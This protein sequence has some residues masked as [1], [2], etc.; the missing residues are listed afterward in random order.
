[1]TTD[2]TLP[3]IRAYDAERDF[4]AVARIW[5]EIRWIEPG[6]DGEKPLTDFLASGDGEVG[7]ANGEAECFVHRTLGDITY[8][9][10]QLSL[11]AITA[12][13]TSQI[14]R[15]QGFATTLTTRALRHGAEA[16]AAVAALGMFEQGFYDRFGFGTGGYDH[17]VTFDPS[18][19]RV[20]HVPYRTPVRLG[21]DDLPDMFEAV[22]RRHRHHCAVTLDAPSVIGAEIAWADHP[23]TL[24][25]RDDDGRLTHF[26][27]GD[28]ADENGP[29]KLHYVIY[30]T[31]DQ[32]MEL[33]R[34]LREL[35]DQ[36]HAVK[37]AEPAEF[38]LQTLLD[39]PIRQRNRSR[40]SD[41]ASGVESLA[42]WQL[43]V[44][45]VGTCVAARHW[46]GSEFA[47]NLEVTD[48]LEHR[49]REA[50][51]IDGWMGV[52]GSYAVTIGPQSTAV[53]G[54]DPTL[55]TL[56]ADVGTFS[57]LW[58]GVESASALRTLGALTA[59]DELCASLDE[60]LRFGRTVTGFPF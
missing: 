24:G 42:W 44:L 57:R 5:R 25:Y 20:D 50:E 3:D 31:P 27:S 40:K 49:I 35:G 51:L 13:T 26:L 17:F 56:A 8:D 39:T 9:A 16:G 29:F 6:E 59:P 10:T 43:R 52:G 21:T 2:R 55:P 28:L 53:L 33:L 12:V 48:P 46:S 18:T 45:D 34:L 22:R 1:M 23:F 14:G 58:F 47:F 60:S 11:C 7:L 38:S 15:K 32:L 36:I 41:L 37:I 30:E 54:G 19:L 4:S